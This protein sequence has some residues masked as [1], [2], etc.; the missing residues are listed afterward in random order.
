[1]LAAMTESGRWP[2]PLVARQFLMVGVLGGYTTFSSFSL[3]TLLLLR[4]GAAVTAGLNVLASVVLC[5]FAAWC[6]FA[7]MSVLNRV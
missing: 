2:L 6:G 5:V 4:N 1:M 3:Q 7:L